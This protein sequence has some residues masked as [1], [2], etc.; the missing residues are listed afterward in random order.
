MN[1]NFDVI[2][3]MLHEATTLATCSTILE[4][5]HVIYKV[6]GKV[7]TNRIYNYTE[8]PTTYDSLTYNMGIK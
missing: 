1:K 3:A 6:L 7:S 5:L 8:M 4:S 2:Q